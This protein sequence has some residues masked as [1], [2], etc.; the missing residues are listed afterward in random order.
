M[1]SKK[2][3]YAI[4]ALIVL[5]ENYDKPPMK[6]S[7]IAEKGHIPKKFL[8]QILLL[9]RNSGLLSSK[10]GAHGGYNLSK[11]SRE[12]Y[13]AQ[14]MRIT[15][16]PIAMVP[17]VSLNFYSRCTECQEEKT[18]GIRDV[19]TD[20]RDSTLRILAETSIFDVIQRENQLKG[21]KTDFWD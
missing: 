20:V 15:D 14:I 21:N 9:L 17:C 18:C 1:L 19:F 16:G 5:G 2:A 7:A 6:I 11:D 12:I 10:K 13:I 4:R 8:E 3:K